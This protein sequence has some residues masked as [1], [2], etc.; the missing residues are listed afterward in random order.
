VDVYSCRDSH[1]LNADKFKVLWRLTLNFEAQFDC[2][3]N[4][5]HQ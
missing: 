3:A 5:F 1:A 4:S 2:L